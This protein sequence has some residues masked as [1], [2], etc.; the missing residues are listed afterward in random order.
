M[1]AKR[2]LPR[3]YE[4]TIDRLSHE[5]RGVGRYLGKTVFVADALPGELVVAQVARR[6]R[7]YD[8]AVAVEFLKTD[9][10]RVTPRCPHAAICGGCSL[11]HLEPATQIAHKQQVLLEHLQHQAGVTPEQVLEPILG[12]LWGYR[13][14]A[15]LSVRFVPKKGG[16]LIGFREKATA[17]VTAIDVCAVLVPSVG[18]RLPALRA[19]VNS[20]SIPEHIPQIEIAADDNTTVLVLRHLQA[21]SPSDLEILVGFEVETGL[22]IY[23]QAGSLASLVPVA[24]GAALAYHVDG[25]TF[26]FQPGDF[27]QVNADINRALVHAAV[28]A[29][30]P[31]TTDSV[32]DLFCGLGN[33]TLPLA[34]RAGQVVGVENEQG[35][36]ER[37]RDNAARNGLTNVE[38]I[39]ADLFR[40]DEL[41]ALSAR[42]FTKIL[43]DPPRS[44]AEL[45]LRAISLRGVTRLVYI[46]CNP[47]TLARD[48]AILVRE[49]GLRLQAAGVIDMFPHTAHVESLAVFEPGNGG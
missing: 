46:S 42:P 36:V 45:L 48:T 2:D 47:V 14:R 6:H 22:K 41:G 27:V 29:L 25:F 23:L 31:T 40:A 8:E 7:R 18:E 20:L 11:Q 12:P 10:A 32:L 26:A 33:F 21:F 9:P 5:G 35:L 17:Y 13:R 28:D 3:R 37:A 1:S 38:F 24:A 44:G 43:L 4:V 34:R 49:R 30:S 19:M 15:R 16:V 39:R